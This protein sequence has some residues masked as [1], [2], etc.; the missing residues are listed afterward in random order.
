MLIMQQLQC[1]RLVQNSDTGLA[2]NPPHNLH[3]FRTVQMGPQRI[4]VP[5]LRKRVAPLLN[6]LQIL[7]H[8]IQHPVNPAVL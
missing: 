5:V 7:L 3:I 4:A 6:L 2:Y 8:L 1:R